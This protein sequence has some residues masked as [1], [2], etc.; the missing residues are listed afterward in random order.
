M[1]SPARKY[2]SK[3]SGNRVLIFGGS[4]G[5]G[6]CVAE[7]ALEHGATV[8]ISGSGSAKL[9]AA[10]DKLK[11]TYPD[12]ATNVH[13][14]TCDLSQPQAL[15]AN[16]EALFKSACPD[17]SSKLDHI[18]FCAG[19]AIKPISIR[20]AT[21]DSFQA[22]SYVRL[23]GSAM[24]GK[25]GPKYLV[26]GPASSIIFTSGTMSDKGYPGLAANSAYCVAR[27]GLARALAVELAPIR[28]NCVSP[29]AI[30]TPSLDS[31]P[32]EHR[33]FVM[34]TLAKETLA[35]VMGR[36][37]DVAEAY[38]YAMKDRFLTGS[39]IKSEGGRLLV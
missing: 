28:V 32:A 24:V 33:E 5:I 27:E 2:I 15:E 25:L 39:V 4:S 9:T 20:D 34:T 17:A 36:P 1:A 14:Y 31:V 29:G 22:A 12:L 26:P 3:L 37:E 30:A 38:V 19:N 8:I 10:I 16:L 35:G 7:A 6:F 18:V 11:S 13:G 23:L 21:V